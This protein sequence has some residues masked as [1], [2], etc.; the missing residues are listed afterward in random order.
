[1]LIFKR[2]FIQ[3]CLIC[4]PSDSTVSEDAGIEPRDTSKNFE[5]EVWKN[6]FGEKKHCM[7]FEKASNLGRLTVENVYDKKRQPR[8]IWV[9]YSAVLRSNPYQSPILYLVLVLVWLH[10]M[11]Q[12]GPLRMCLVPDVVPPLAGFLFL[13][14]LGVLHHGL[15]VVSVRIFETAHCFRPFYVPC[16]HDSVREEISPCFQS[17]CLWPHV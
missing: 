15:S 6:V 7:F 9:C 5:G 3:H 4:H 11:A 14:V 1:M 2:T 16:F 17:R 12:V 13:A 8:S 10:P